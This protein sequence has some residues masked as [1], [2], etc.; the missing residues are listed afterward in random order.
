MPKINVPFVGSYSAD[1]QNQVPNNSNSIT[2]HNN[3]QFDVLNEPTTA[4][5]ASTDLCF[6]A[7]ICLMCLIS[8]ACTNV[9]Y[10]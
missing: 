4:T 10:T 7:I 1:L 5:P 6:P 9:V 3:I 8:C 2:D